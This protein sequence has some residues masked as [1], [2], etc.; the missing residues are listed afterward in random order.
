MRATSRDPHPKPRFSAKSGHWLACALVAVTTTGCGMLFPDLPAE[1]EILDAPFDGLSGAQLRVHLAGDE[2]FGR[3]FGPEDGLGPLFVSNSCESC[4]VGEGKGHLL[5]NIT[6]FGRVGE[7]FDAMR[8]MGGPQLQNRALPGYPPEVVPEGAGAVSQFMP[9]SIT[10]LGYL[11]AVDDTTLLRLADPDDED[12]DGISGRVQLLDADD[13]VS[14]LVSL[15]AVVQG[16]APT[17]G[18]LIDGKVIGR[19]GRKASTVNL[20]H[21]VVTAL[22]ED[23]GLTSDLVPRDLLN[24]QVG[25]LATDDVAD[26]EV[27]SSTVEALTFYLRTLRR[28]LPRDANDADVQAGESIFADIGCGACH[29]PTLRT[30]ASEIPQLDRVEFHAYTD[31]L[32]HD[33]GEALDDGYTEGRAAGGEWR[34]TPLWGIGLSAEFQGGQAFYLHDGRARTLVEAIEFHG[35][36]AAASRER[37]RALSAEDRERLLR[38]L[39]SL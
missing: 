11:E 32:L 24:R 29:L 4:H 20:L 26:P 14:E 12:G 8:E 33:L 30:G 34:T 37:F 10:G 13:F 18:T 15:D 21:Q 28:P 22:S 6:R 39:R 23:M 7:P 27:A 25:S 16:N 1:D 3:S 5:F 38:F 2:A 9:P 36:E 19:F 17:R 31:L 35:G